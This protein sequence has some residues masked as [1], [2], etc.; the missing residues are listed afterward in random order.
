MNTAG[1]T[2]INK[3]GCTE[4]H[5][6]SQLKYICLR[7]ECLPQCFVCSLCIQES[8]NG[9]HH[10]TIDFEDFKSNIIPQLSANAI[11]GNTEF[12]SD[13][14]QSRERLLKKLS[15]VQAQM[16]HLIKRIRL[17]IN[18]Q[19]DTII[20]S[21]N[22]ETYKSELAQLEKQVTSKKV[23]NI[24]YAVQIIK[25]NQFNNK[26]ENIIK[27]ENQYDKLLSELGDSFTQ[28]IIQSQTL[29]YVG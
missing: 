11:Y 1:R 8:H 22:Q 18:N 14:K 17:A 29:K 5:S 21:Y 2:N 10:H 19:F 26:N 25:R 20:K 4:A 27:A 28:M 3:P 12:L 16:F 23:I 7:P 6:F 15:E 24:C 9:P 13:L